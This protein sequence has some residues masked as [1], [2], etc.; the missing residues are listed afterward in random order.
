MKFCLQWYWTSRRFAAGHLFFG[1][2]SVLVHAK[3]LSYVF[4][5]HFFH[6]L[7]NDISCRCDRSLALRGI[8][9]WAACQKKSSGNDEGE[10]FGHVRGDKT[11]F[12]G[13][14]RPSNIFHGAF[15]EIMSWDRLILLADPLKTLLDGID[16]LR[17]SAE[18]RA[19]G[20]GGSQSNMKNVTQQHSANTHTQVIFPGL[21]DL[22]W[23]RRIFNPRKQME[24]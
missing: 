5:S 9:M 12:V 10:A 16:T 19:G 14:D 1:G 15:W 3:W 22:G 24:L 23:A 6:P 8:Q 17:H 18:E 21:Q 4:F 20:G 7:T 11:Y 13:N 2:G